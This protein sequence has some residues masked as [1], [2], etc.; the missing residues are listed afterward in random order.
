M[1]IFSILE[2]ISDPRRDHLKKYSVESIFP[3]LL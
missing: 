2:K 3:L 1:E